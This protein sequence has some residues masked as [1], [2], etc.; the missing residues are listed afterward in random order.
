MISNARIYATVSCL[1]GTIAEINAG[2]VKRLMIMALATFPA[3]DHSRIV[4]IPAV[5]H[6]I[7]ALPALPAINLVRYVASIANAPILVAIRVPLVRSNA[8]GLVITGAIAAVCHAR[9][10]AI[11]FLAIVAAKRS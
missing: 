1:A 3:G 10:H 5:N 4:R 8:D 6:A 2:G 9:S 11:S 7:L